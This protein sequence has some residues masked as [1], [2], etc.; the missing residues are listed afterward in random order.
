MSDPKQVEQEQ[1][2]ENASV[3]LDVNV[4]ATIHSILRVCAKRGAFEVSE[5]PTVTRV[6]DALESALEPYME[7]DAQEVLDTQSE[8]VDTENN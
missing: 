2:V 7:K 1:E 5:F 4:V 6:N 8:E 3:E